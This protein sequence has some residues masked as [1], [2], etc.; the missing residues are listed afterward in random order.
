M[1]NLLS[2]ILI[3]L[4]LLAPLQPL[5]ASESQPETLVTYI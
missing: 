5:F 3:L 4:F 2:K 1:K